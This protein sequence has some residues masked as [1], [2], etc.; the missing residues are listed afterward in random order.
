[1]PRNKK[2]FIFHLNHCFT[3]SQIRIE[4]LTWTLR[5]LTTPNYGISIARSQK[6]R[7]LSGIPLA[8]LPNKI[9][10]LC[11]SFALVNK[12]ERD[13]YSKQTIV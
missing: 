2:L 5:L 4:Q 11:G 3:Y 13:D 12:I 8:S 10:H 6:L 9:I 1:M 7:K